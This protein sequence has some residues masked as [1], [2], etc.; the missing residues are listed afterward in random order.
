MPNSFVSQMNL[1]TSYLDGSF[2]YGMI[3]K[4]QKSWMRTYS[5]GQLTMCN[6]NILPR[7]DDMFRTG[8]FRSGQSPQL[9]VI[10]SLFYREHNRIAKI[11][12]ELNEFWNDEKL[13]QEARRIIIALLQQYTYHELLPTYVGR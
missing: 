10:H 6:Q 2:V 12:H 8:D 4:D 9:S 13:F 3:T 11:L 1:V 5:N 7:N